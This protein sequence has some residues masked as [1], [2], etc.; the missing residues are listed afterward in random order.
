MTEYNYHE[1][2]KEKQKPATAASLQT[3][4]LLI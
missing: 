2:D 4:P 3:R 1:N